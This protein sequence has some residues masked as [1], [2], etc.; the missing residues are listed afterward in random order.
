VLRSELSL[1]LNQALKSNR[2]KGLNASPPPKWG[3]GR[4]KK[5]RI[6]VLFTGVN[7]LSGV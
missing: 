5:K 7:S 4:W 2:F 1:L 6:T 3:F